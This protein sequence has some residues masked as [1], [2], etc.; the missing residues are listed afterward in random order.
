[1]VR[2]TGHLSGN[3]RCAP[4]A[5]GSAIAAFETAVVRYA[6][7]AAGVPG[8]QC[9]GML[10]SQTRVSSVA[11]RWS[12]I[13]TRRNVAAVCR[14]KPG[15]EFVEGG[16]HGGPCHLALDQADEHLVV[17]F[18]DSGL[19]PVDSHG[20]DAGDR[21]ALFYRSVA[22]VADFAVVDEELAARDAFKPGPVERSAVDA[23]LKKASVSSASRW[24]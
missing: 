13:G 22:V 6:D 7:F 23:S 24:G 8:G 19:D 2:P 17:G 10:R 15:V 1:M 9:S 3:A 21:S 4:T 5:G 16:A 14:S 12:V 20:G 18:L 11:V